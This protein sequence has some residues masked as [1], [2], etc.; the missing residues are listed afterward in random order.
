MEED[1]RPALS[2]ESVVAGVVDGSRDSAL[3]RYNGKGI[4]SGQDECRGKKNSRVSP[5]FLHLKFLKEPF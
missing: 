3:Y 5:C 1:S 2:K 4:Y